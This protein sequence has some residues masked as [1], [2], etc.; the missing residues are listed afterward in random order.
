MRCNKYQF[1]QHVRADGLT[2]MSEN[3]SLGNT[4]SQVQTYPGQ[5]YKDGY[6]FG[7]SAK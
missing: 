1:L 5:A 3:S 4:P 2:A 7:A 6:F